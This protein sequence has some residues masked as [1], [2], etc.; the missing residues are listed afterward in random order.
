MIWLT[1]AQRCLR[2]GWLGCG[3]DFHG[4]IRFDKV[5]TNTGSLHCAIDGETVDC[6]GRD[7]GVCGLGERQQ[8]IPFGDDNKKGNSR[9][10]ASLPS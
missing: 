10:D 7:D 4:F 5:K 6:F 3:C 2:R 9:L 8:Q 1:F